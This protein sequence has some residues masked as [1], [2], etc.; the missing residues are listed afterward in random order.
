MN[1]LR[2]IGLLLC[3][4]LSQFGLAQQLTIQITQGVDNPIPIAIV[5]FE[6]EGFGVLPENITDVVNSDLRNSGEFAPLAEQ[7]MLSLPHEEN[8]VV[9][10]D[11]RFLG[12]DYLLIGKINRSANSTLIEVQYELFDVRGEQRMIGEVISGTE[13]QLRDISHQISDVVFEKITGVRGAFATKILY[14]TSQRASET[15]TN[16][17]LNLADADGGRAQVLLQSQEP[18]M[19]P[20]W[21]PD[22]KK[23]AY[24][25]FESTLPRIYIQDLATGE[26]EKI[27]DFPRNNSAPQW[28]PDG[29]KMAMTLSK[30]GNPDI[31]VMDLRTRELRKVTTHFAAD[32]EPSWMPDGKS[33]LYTSEQAGN[34]RPQIYQVTLDTGWSDRVTY[35]GNW[36]SEASILPD[37]NNV[38]LIHREDANDK[39]HLAIHN[40]ERGTLRILTDTALDESPTV[41]PNASMIMYAS[42]SGNRGILNA[43]SID[44]RVKYQLPV[45]DGDVREPAWSPFLD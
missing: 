1:K 6:W 32:T 38:V 39:F 43:V 33:L 30:D 24:V 41:A 11:W 4:L 26:R 3:G 18:I 13:A 35:Q 27:T 5:P 10:R 19:S 28:S 29:T 7:N 40:I 34:N 12:S 8:Q 44:G 20:T 15:I 25:S 23:I 31:Y 17:Q 42:K 21:S 45:M 9:F 14:I 37:G 36:N 22:A 16:Y 2:F